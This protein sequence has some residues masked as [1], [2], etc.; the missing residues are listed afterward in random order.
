MFLILLATLFQLP[1][2][3][4]L[5]TTPPATT[6]KQ[7][8]ATTP[9]PKPSPLGGAFAPEQQTKPQYPNQIGGKSHGEWI[10]EL[11]ESKDAAVREN[12][13]KVLPLFGPSAR[14]TSIRPLVKAARE[15]IDP[16]VRVNAI[17]SLGMVGAN[18]KEE[19]RVIIEA[20][21]ISILNSP[22]GGIV[23]LHATRAI[24]Y[25][26]GNFPDQANDAIGTLRD[27]AKDIS[28]ETRKTV[29]FALGRIGGPT[30]EKPKETKT[31]SRPI[32]PGTPPP[33]VDPKTGP[34]PSA[35]KILISMMNDSSAMVRLEAV[36][37]L[38][39]LG[40]PAVSLDK[41][42]LVIQ[43]YMTAL[44]DRM[45][46]EKDKG[47]QIWLVMLLMRYDGN[48]FNEK[49]MQKIV[50]L[51]RSAEPEATIQALTALSL[52]DK[53]G[54]VPAIPF[55]R[56]MLTHSEPL[57][58]AMAANYLAGTKT[59]GKVALP[60]LEVAKK[61]AE[62]TLKDETLKAVINNAIDAINGKA[63]ATA[64]NPK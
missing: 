19:A 59:A 47:V 6:G 15:D 36:Q 56:D 55:A 8:P 1:P 35:I 38:V 2:A 10:K 11:G 48:S 31:E 12:A 9:E 3:G 37:S 21:R 60:E 24:A 57:V 63:P 33:P 26:G 44:Q 50:E 41:Y 5:P 43:P 54:H 25:Y 27:I 40:P 20:L 51:G 4:Q 16:G 62:T 49:N 22:P 18:S 39:M 17:L 42:S 46:Q 45:K 23:R 32:L 64:G 30:K 7:P 53:D 52:L 29:A 61:K 14:D 13:V 34:E 28:W 58:I